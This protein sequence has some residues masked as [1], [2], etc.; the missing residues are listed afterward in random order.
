[1]EDEILK[2]AEV[3]IEAYPY[4]KKYKGKTFVI[5]IGGSILRIDEAKEDI[6]QDIAFLEVVGI[7]VILICGGGPFITEEIEKRGGKAK[8]IDGLRITDKKTLEIVKDVLYNVRDSIINEL[9]NKFNLSASS[10]TPEEKFITG[11]KIHYQRG[12]EVVDLGFVGQVADVNVKYIEEKVKK[13]KV[14]VVAPLAFDKEG[15]LLNINGDA[16]S[17]S[18]AENMKAEKLIFITDVLG[19]MRHPEKAET[20]ISVLELSQGDDLINKKIIKEG[21]IP[22]VRSAMKAIRKGVKKVHII[23]G[24]VSHSILLEVFTKS[25][26]GTEIVKNGEKAD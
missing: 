19:I 8:F 5:K 15:V 4:I 22:K 17:S 6:L 18:I 13:E 1:M 26:I 16:V 21:M 2:K 24:N 12:E 11:K 10:L 3:L 23:S 25:G 20:L 14:L 9:K 7:N